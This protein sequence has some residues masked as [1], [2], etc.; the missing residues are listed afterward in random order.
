MR[1]VLLCCVLK[2]FV[3]FG[4]PV[5]LHMLCL[6]ESCCVLLSSVTLALMCCVVL[7]CVLLSCASFL[8]VVKYSVVLH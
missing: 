4:C 3:K 2:C 5:L 7:S 6:V 8:F 1:C